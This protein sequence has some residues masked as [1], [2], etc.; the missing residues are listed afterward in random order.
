MKRPGIWKEDIRSCN[1][2][3]KVMTEGYVIEGGLSY[4][5]SKPCLLKH[6]TEA[7]WEE[8]YGDGETDSYWTEW[9]D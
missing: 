9:E 7:E 1:H 3:R 4:Y 8:L 6:C 2:C 5:C